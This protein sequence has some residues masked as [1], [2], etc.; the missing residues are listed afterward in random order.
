ML[1][2][3][4]IEPPI[5]PPTTEPIAV[6]IISAGPKWI[7]FPFGEYLKIAQSLIGVLAILTGFKEN[8]FLCAKVA[9]TGV[10]PRAEDARI[11]AFCFVFKLFCSAC[12]CPLKLW[13]CELFTL[14]RDILFS[15]YTSHNL[16]SIKN[17]T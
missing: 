8:P 7:Y 15:I 13:I 16:H 17:K 4:T 2:L 6:A 11:V 3:S 1:S 12:S 5:N 9:I 10:M 14:Y